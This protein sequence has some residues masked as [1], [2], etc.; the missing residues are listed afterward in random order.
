MECNIHMILDEYAV[1]VWFEMTSMIADKSCTMRSSIT[2]F[3]QPFWNRKIQ[4]VEKM[5]LGMRSHLVLYVK[6]KWC[7][8]E[9]KLCD[10]KTEKWC[11][12]ED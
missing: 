3:L 10:L 1:R 4:W 7:D 5:N 9:Q 12:L 6:Q 8:L 2:T 11:N